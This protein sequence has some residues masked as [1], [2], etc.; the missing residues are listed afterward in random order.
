VWW[1]QLVGV[2]G[3][4]VLMGAGFVAGRRNGAP[5]SKLYKTVLFGAGLVMLA[6]GVYLLVITA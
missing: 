1:L 4:G 2:V 5:R 6:A 3:F